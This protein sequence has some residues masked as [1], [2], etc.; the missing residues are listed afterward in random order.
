MSSFLFTIFQPATT[1]LILAPLSN[2]K[3][4]LLLRVPLAHNLSTYL[5]QSV[6]LGYSPRTTLEAAN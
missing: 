2:L 3:V 1:Y 4:Y 6:H 5:E